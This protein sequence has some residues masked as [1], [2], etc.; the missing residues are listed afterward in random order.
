MLA[1]TPTVRPRDAETP[2][3]ASVDANGCTPV[4]AC[5]AVVITSKQSKKLCLLIHSDDGLKLCKV[6]KG[7]AK[8]K[9]CRAR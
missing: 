4:Q 9:I 5:A 6:A 7:P 3:G 8:T 2:E 1:T